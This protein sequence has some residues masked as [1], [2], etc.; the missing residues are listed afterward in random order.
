MRIDEAVDPPTP[1]LRPDLHDVTVR[2]PIP[3][4]R[5]RGGSSQPS[6]GSNVRQG[7][8]AF[9][10]GRGSLDPRTSM[11]PLRIPYSDVFCERRIL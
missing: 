2:P 7:A 10:G 1:R 11:P 6:R 4:S 3:T 9:I 5:L 8:E